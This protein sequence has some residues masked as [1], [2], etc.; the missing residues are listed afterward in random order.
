VTAGER[1]VV[2]IGGAI[3]AV[4]LGARLAPVGAEAVGRRLDLARSRHAVAVRARAA[5]ARLPVLQDSLVVRA[6]ELISVAPMLFDGRSSPEISAALNHRL[7]AAAAAAQVT[8]EQLESL[9]DSPA[10][11][12]VRV[13]SRLRAVA[14]L[15]G[16]AT[17]LASLE[18]GPQLMTLAW[19]AV[20]NERGDA[21]PQALRLDLVVSAWGL[22]RG[23]E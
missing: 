19:F 7:D 23:V 8:I 21:E 17:F 1:R 20:V 15:E 11:G 5:A 3:V 14:D 2:F 18:R 10:T 22:M 13:Q 12:F 6:R 9:P 4:G 16:V